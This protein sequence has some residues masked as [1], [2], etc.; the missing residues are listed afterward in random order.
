M[1]R[2]FK[3]YSYG[4]YMGAAS[5]A[6]FDAGIDSWEYWVLNVP[7]VILVEWSKK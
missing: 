6:L 7:V 3:D 5:V 2:F 1:K 4:L